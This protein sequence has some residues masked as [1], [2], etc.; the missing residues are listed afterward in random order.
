MAVDMSNKPTVLKV[1][2]HGWRRVV[3]NGIHVGCVHYHKTVV[4]VHGSP[5]PISGFAARVS[6]AYIPEGPVDLDT[7]A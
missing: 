1:F 7:R 6:T 2:G 3:P 4:R 5:H